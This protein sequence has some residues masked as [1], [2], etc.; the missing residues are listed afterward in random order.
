MSVFGEN[1]FAIGGQAPAIARVYG[2]TFDP[3]EYVSV[4]ASLEQGRIDDAQAGL[5]RRTAASMGIGFSGQD[6]R[7]TSAVEMRQET[8]E[9][10]EQEVWLLRNSA[11]FSLGQDWRYLS[12]LNIA[13]ADA[14][15]QS[16]RAAEFTEASIGAA[17]RPAEQ[18][19]LNGL[20]RLHYFEDMGPLGQLTGSGRTE[21]PKQVSMILSAD[22]NYS[23]TQRLTLGAKYGYR[24]GKVSLARSSADFVSSEAHLGVIRADYNAIGAWDILAEARSL[25]V[26]GA[27]ERKLGALLAVYRHLG[28]NVKLG[29][30]YSWSDFSDNLTD[31]TYTSRGTFLNLL[32]AF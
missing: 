27:H 31:Q 22:G 25:S 19:R 9:R 30:G 5:M 24:Q 21:S 2:L 26:S 29:A 14:D 3:A 17:Y 32:A 23:L 1:R 28:E 15:G 11:S 4:T 10:G 8:G 18:Q 13:W 7:V 20:A 16:I 12:D 6:Y